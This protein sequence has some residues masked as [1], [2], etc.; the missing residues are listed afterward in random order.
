MSKLCHHCGNALDVSTATCTRCNQTNT[1]GDLEITQVITPASDVVKEAAIVTQRNLSDFEVLGT[2]SG[3]FATILKAKDPVLDR[4]VAL[5]LVPNSDQ[6]SDLVQEAKLASK[7]SHPNI[8]TIHEIIQND[9]QLAIVMEW[10]DGDNLKAKIATEIPLKEKAHIALQLCNA[11]EYAHKND[12]LHCDIKP[13]NIMFD[14]HNQLKVL[15]FGLSHVL[16]GESQAA[17]IGSPAYLAPELY[18]GQN[19]SKQSDLFALGAVLFELFS[20]EKAFDGKSLEVIKAQITTGEAKNLADK[21]TQL[22]E[23]LITLIQNLLVV[24]PSER[25]QLSDLIDAFT[26]LNQAL[27]QKPNW[28]QRRAPW[29]K[30]SLSAVFLGVMAVLLQP[31]LFPPSNQQILE[32]RISENKRI[33][34]L[35]LQNIN[36][37]P[38]VQ[39][40][41][42]GLAVTLSTE[43]GKVGREKTNSWVIPSAEVAKLK[44]LT[45]NDVHTRYGADLVLT[46]SIQHLGSQRLINLELIDGASGVSLNQQQF[47]VNV[48]DLFASNQAVFDKAITMLNW[49]KSNMAS[50]GTEFDGAYKHYITGIGYSFRFDV[51]ENIHSAIEQFEMA[52]TLDNYYEAAHIGLAETYLSKYQLTKDAIWLDK[53]NTT[54]MRMKTFASE[55]VQGYFRAVIAI[56]RGEAQEAVKELSAAISIKPEDE[57][58]HFELA[59]AYQQL[60][61]N[62]LAEKSYLEGLRITPNYWRG[63]GRLGGFYFRT[64][65]FY[66]A[67]RAYTNLKEITPHN[68]AAYVGLSA[69]YYNLGE[70]D[71]ALAASIKA[72]EIKPSHTGFSNIGALQFHLG[73]YQDSINSYKEALK[74]SS[75]H[76]VTWGNLADSYWVLNSDKADSTYQKAAEYAEKKLETNKQ[77]S[78]ARFHLAYYLAKLNR[79]EESHTIL[80]SL[81]DKEDNLEFYLAA[82]SYDSMGDVERALKSIKIALEKGY[83]KSEVK[84]SPLW[85]HINADVR[86]KELMAE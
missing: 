7:L 32:K 84:S 57:R 4:I 44:N 36:D 19:A 31:I 62:E 34:V 14:I 1:G 50:K 60:N 71:K 45:V 52:I 82:L 83:S 42:Q 11:I 41:S 86:F 40:F 47:K 77:D 75:T 2:V 37:D 46:G 8:V 25:P 28:W 38:Q 76:F 6:Q 70:I 64:G 24:E 67:A 35:P 53:V 29:Q 39:L 15:D 20:G 9:E 73:H 3:G 5:K 55:N 79:V 59:R 80:E 21:H 22:P 26:D 66:K 69:S 30:V 16:G 12:I 13:D 78:S 33:A 23:A 56:R 43:L 18:L 72:N 74:L 27:V 48:K 85:N 51:G 10:V 49:P 81:S 61:N 63:I 68:F 54:V 17:T 58:L 65:Q